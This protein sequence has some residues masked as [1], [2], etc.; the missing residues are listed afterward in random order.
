MSGLTAS[1]MR[2]LMMDVWVVR[3]AMREHLM[4]MQVRVGL[5][6]GAI[7]VAMSMVLVVDMAVLM[8]EGLVR[9][10]MLVAFAH[11]QPDAQQHKDRAYG[12]ACA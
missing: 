8:H 9:M 5:I 3:M 1:R 6:C 10:L 12:E 7:G 11:M 2:V 4:A